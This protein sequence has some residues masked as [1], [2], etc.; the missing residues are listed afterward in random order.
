[1]RSTAVV[2]LLV[3]ACASSPPAVPD[4]G[5]PAEVV[6]PQ[7]ADPPPPKAPPDDAGPLVDAAPPPED[8][9][10]R[11]EDAAAPPRDSGPIG[12]AR[13]VTVHVPP[14]YVAGKPTPLVVLLHGYTATGDTQEAYLGLTA[15]ADS[16]GFLYA[17]PDGTTDVFGMQFWNATDACCDLAGT[18]VDDS[19]Y[20]SG[21]ITEI[22]ARYSVDPKRVFLIGH[23]NG[24]F[25]SYRMA[26]DHSDQIAALVSIAGA[27]WG[28]VARCTPTSPV[29]VL[30]VHG[31]ADLV[32]GYDGGA[33]FGHAY[34]SAPAT[35]ADWVTLDGCSPTPDT[36]AERLDLEVT[37][38]GPDTTVTKYGGCK[39]GGHA[40]LWAIQGGGHIPTFTSD[41]ASGAVDFLLAHP[42]P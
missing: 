18:G 22:S 9:A 14:G 7:A 33:I 24:G 39:P 5:A 8:A 19:A 27:M 42:K 41:F 31:T 6:E 28:D 2:A 36:S 15:L 40:E 4:P 17:H 12:G 29:S 30:E 26:C 32:I 38:A 3:A 34:P 13:P 20:L 21:V 35:V 23:S 16:R 11:V 25:M 1:M 10:P 37:L